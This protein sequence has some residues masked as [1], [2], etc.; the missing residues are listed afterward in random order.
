MEE[1]RKA[2]PPAGLS[3][4]GDPAGRALSAALSN[5]AAQ[6]E[7]L[8]DRGDPEAVHRARVAA[9]RLLAVLQTASASMTP[10]RRRRLDRYSGALGKFVKSLGR[11]R[12]LDVALQYVAEVD[13]SELQR[14][15]IAGIERLALRMGQ[16][17]ESLQTRVMEAVELL[18]SSK[19]IQGLSSIA[20]PPAGKAP[21]MKEGRHARL[22]PGAGRA[23]R[24]ALVPLASLDGPLS[25]ED[26]REGQHSARIA[27]KKARYA[28]E[29]F[30]DALPSIAAERLALLR[31]LQTLLGSIHDRDVW[32]DRLASF[33]VREAERSERFNGT[34]KPFARIL[35]GI[36]YMERRMASER[37]RAFR[38]L[39]SEWRRAARKGFPGDLIEAVGRPGTPPGAGAPVEET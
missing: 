6:V 30:E 26:D 27:I 37:R 31:R 9:R 33:R 34:A 8:G 7:S 12:D 22:S 32:I 29:P 21:S 35:P 25:R 24:E 16:E 36:E 17:R 3:R 19:T 18:R 15:Q 5:L 10:A 20:R 11:A 14:S 4:P 39:L 1:R 28:L 13:R 38:K 23:I 2:A